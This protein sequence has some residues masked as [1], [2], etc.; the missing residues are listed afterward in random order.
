MQEGR[1]N[2][3]IALD[4]GQKTGMGQEVHKACHKE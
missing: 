4:I 3:Y 1:E 2:N